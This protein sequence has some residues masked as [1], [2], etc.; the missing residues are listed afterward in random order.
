[1]GVPVV[2]L[3]GRGIH[4]RSSTRQDGKSA[5]ISLYIQL[6]VESFISLMKI[7]DSFITRYDII[8]IEKR[9]S[10]SCEAQNVGASLL[11]AVQLGDLVTSTE[12][13]F[14]KQAALCGQNLPRLAALRA[15]LRTRMLRRQVSLFD[16]YLVFPLSNMFSR[17][18]LRKHFKSLLISLF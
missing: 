5:H 11:S 10:G 18:L 16:S 9:S 13:D 6:F 7:L 17:F 14:V 15:G 2:T 12:E 8:R 4:A 1:M 3:K